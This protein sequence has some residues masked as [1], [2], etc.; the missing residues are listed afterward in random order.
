MTILTK[1]DHG[2]ALY[3]DIM[4]LTQNSGASGEETF[5]A[6]A[7]AISH[8]ISLQS[9]DLQ[10]AEEWQY[11]LGE[12]VSLCLFNAEVDGSATWSRLRMH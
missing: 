10:T 8:V 1:R 11:N 5:K 6:L 12:T 9:P 7:S 4:A 2:Y 3:K